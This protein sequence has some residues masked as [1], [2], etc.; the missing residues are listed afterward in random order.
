MI[1]IRITKPIP[2]GRKTTQP[3]IGGIYEV[4]GSRLANPSLFGIDS[5]KVYF[6]N[7]GKCIVGV[8][9]NECEVVEV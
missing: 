7:V 2:G 8:R 4:V 5:Q 6:I 3:E 1:K 9:Q